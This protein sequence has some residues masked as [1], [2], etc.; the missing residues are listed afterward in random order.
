MDP[1]GDFFRSATWSSGMCL[2]VVTQVW[3]ESP[4]GC[5]ETRAFQVGPKKMSNTAKVSCLYHYISLKIKYIY[6]H[7]YMYIY[8]SSNK[9]KKH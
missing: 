6:V 2:D 1:H 5:D 9:N 8:I 7:A 4:E 3:D